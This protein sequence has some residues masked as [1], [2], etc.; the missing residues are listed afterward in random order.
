MLTAP[1]IVIRPIELLPRLVNQRAPSGPAAIP[2][3]SEMLGSA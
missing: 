1:A 2:S 3:G